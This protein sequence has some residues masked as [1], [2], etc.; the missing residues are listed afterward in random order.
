T[1]PVGRP[2]SPPPRALRLRVVSGP[3]V[4][5]SAVVSHRP[6]IVGRAKNADLQL[7]D[8]ATSSFQVEVTASSE[9]I[10]VRDL[11]SRNGTYHAGT[12]IFHGIVP[13]GAHLE[14]GSS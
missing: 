3:D 7:G 9:G 10:E 14:M 2:E 8:P 1:I 13:A 12:R 6:A 11:G 4:G 5:A